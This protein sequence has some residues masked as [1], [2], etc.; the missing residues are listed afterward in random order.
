MT[1]RKFLTIL[2]PILFML[3]LAIRFFLLGFWLALLVVGLN[4]VLWI[5]AR[6][7]SDPIYVHAALFLST[8]IIIGGWLTA[9][10]PFYGLISSSSLVLINWDLV[11]FDREL[12]LAAS[13]QAVFLE[14]KHF[15]SLVFILFSGLLLGLSGYWFRLN[16]PFGVILILILSAFY[17]LDYI[18]RKLKKQT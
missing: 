12:S 16:I 7:K 6:K 3:P 18:W 8:S 1:L 14:Q 11:Q 10:L 17:C 9:S 5:V 15:T 4:M 13:T 2:F